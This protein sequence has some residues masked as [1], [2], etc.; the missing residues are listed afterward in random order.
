ML[1]EAG[2][3]GV[4]RPP[5]SHATGGRLGGRGG[6][7]LGRRRIGFRCARDVGG[8]LQ[9]VRQEPRGAQTGVLPRR[10]ALRHSV[11]V[12]HGCLQRAG[13]R[14]AQQCSTCAA[15][16]DDEQGCVQAFRRRFLQRRRQRGDT[17]VHRADPLPPRRRLAPGRGGAPHGLTPGGLRPESAR[18]NERRKGVERNGCRQND[19]QQGRARRWLGRAGHEPRLRR[20]PPRCA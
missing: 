17:P 18:G 9:M 11:V 15:C 5:G 7:S 2:R 4:C 14:A 3:R 13:Q 16:R 6:E 20:L 12:Q 8:V 1:R 19:G 10:R